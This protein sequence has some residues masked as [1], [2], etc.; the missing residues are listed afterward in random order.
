MGVK[1]R[2]PED[3]TRRIEVFFKANLNT[4]IGII[5][6]EKTTDEITTNDT[7]IPL[8][9]DRAW[10]LTQL[11]RVWSYQQFVVWGLSR[12]Q[13]SAQQEDNF[14]YDIEWFF[15]VVMP[16]SGTSNNETEFFK[17]LRYARALSQIITKNV[18]EVQRGYKFKVESLIPAT[19]SVAGKK[20]RTGGV[21][22]S[23]KMTAI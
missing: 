8:I 17:L 15:E 22:V 13:P 10:Y 2:D 1:V 19:A 9:E 20:F 14:L 21:L 5:N 23:T 16:D 11:P 18:D 3:L 7:A 12:L 4:Q 6:A